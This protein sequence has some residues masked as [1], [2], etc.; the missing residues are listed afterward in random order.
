[1]PLNN[2]F[3]IEDSCL[4]A[5]Y[6]SISTSDCREKA[7]RP[8]QRKRKLPGLVNVWI[9]LIGYNKRVIV[10][11]IVLDIHHFSVL[12]ASHW[13]PELRLRFSIVFSNFYHTMVISWFQMTTTVSFFLRKILFSLSLS[14]LSF[15]PSLSCTISQFIYHLFYKSVVDYLKLNSCIFD[16]RSEL[17]K[18]GLKTDRSTPFYFRLFYL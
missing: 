4:E 9:H 14:P 16:S 2:G 10:Q 15:L 12:C 5:M 3:I 17:T 6:Y 7:S 8:N 13:S 1:M 11:K 18:K